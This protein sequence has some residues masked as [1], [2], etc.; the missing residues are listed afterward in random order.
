M[1]AFPVRRLFVFLSIYP[2]CSSLIFDN[3]N[4]HPISLW[5]HFVVVI[6][7]F[8]CTHSIYIKRMECSKSGMRRATS[9]PSL[10]TH[11]CKASLRLRVVDLLCV[12]FVYFVIKYRLPTIMLKLHS[13]GLLDHACPLCRS[14]QLF[15]HI[16]LPLDRYHLFNFLVC[17]FHPRDQLILRLRIRRLDLPNCQAYRI[18]L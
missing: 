17:I 4:H 16:P 1:V 10:L 8:F 13:L 7:S 6:P 15:I 11:E 9:T 3:T 2:F 5:L 12:K 14:S 18:F